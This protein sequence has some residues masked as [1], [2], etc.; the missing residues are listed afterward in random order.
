PRNQTLR[1]TWYP[2]NE[3]IIKLVN[4]PNAVRLSNAFFLLTRWA[5]FA[6]D[7]NCLVIPSGV[8]PEGETSD[9]ES[10]LGR[11]SPHCTVGLRRPPVFFRS[12]SACRCSL[13]RTISQEGIGKAHTIGSK[14][15]GPSS[16]ALLP[17]D[18]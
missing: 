3:K 12:S 9:L 13:A 10:P 2:V 14:R 11:M 18:H 7:G 8:Q 6:D 17:R 5:L 16:P 15:G 4:S 1:P